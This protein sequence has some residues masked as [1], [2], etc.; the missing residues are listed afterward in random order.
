MK[1]KNKKILT[2]F[3]EMFGYGGAL[4]YTAILTWLLFQIRKYGTVSISEPNI[5]VILSEMGVGVSIIGFLLYKIR[6][7]LKKREK[8]LSEL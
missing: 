3:L 4:T 6:T 1:E 5:Y 2:G 8:E 7:S